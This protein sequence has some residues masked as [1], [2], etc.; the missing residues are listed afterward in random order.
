LKIWRLNPHITAAEF[1]K[2]KGSA[3][4]KLRAVLQGTGNL[5]AAEKTQKNT[6]ESNPHLNRTLM[7]NRVRLKIVFG[8]YKQT[9]HLKPILLTMCCHLHQ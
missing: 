6:K 5:F 9:R 1:K 2:S 7:A 8:S 4:K 3:I